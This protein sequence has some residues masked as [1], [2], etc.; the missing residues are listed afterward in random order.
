MEKKE[1]IEQKLLDY[2][3]AKDQS[4]LLEKRIGEREKK[5]KEL[6][7]LIKNL[8]MEREKKQKEIE[9]IE[10]D[11]NNLIREI[12]KFREEKD[13]LQERKNE[14]LKDI[15][16]LETKYVNTMA[17]FKNIE[18][19][20]I[21]ELYQLSLFESLDEGY[22]LDITDVMEGVPDKIFSGCSYEEDGKVITPKILSLMS[23]S[24][25]S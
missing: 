9:K 7:T 18:T 19:K 24:H 2:E 8:E 13:M 23:V 15:G 21:K 1:E 4:E 11:K 17:N 22:E 25:R 14:L 10:S 6:E 5:L 3:K 12:K 20:N 16:G